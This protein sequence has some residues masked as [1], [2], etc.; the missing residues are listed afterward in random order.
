MIL[1]LSTSMFTLL[2]VIISLVGISAGLI[3][4]LGLLGGKLY[5]GLTALFLLPRFSPA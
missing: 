2:H 3:A 5:R 4:L 1:G